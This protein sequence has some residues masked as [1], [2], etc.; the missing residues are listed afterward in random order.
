MD[1]RTLVK[2]LPLVTAVQIPASLAAQAPQTDQGMLVVRQGGREL[3]REEFALQPDPNPR[4]QGVTTLSVV[5]TVPGA[6]A[7]RMVIRFDPRTVTVRIATPT[8]EVAREY[9]GQR[10]LLFMDHD[11]FALHALTGGLEAGQVQIHFP[12]SG[13]RA[14]GTLEDAGA[15]RT[16]MGRQERDLR[17]RVLR[18]SDQTY[19]LWFDAAGRLM[20]ATAPD[21]GLVAERANP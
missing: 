10:G 16:M 13:S 17:H 8:G 14:T 21:R 12:R 19:H 6:P 3:A 2:V 11:I 18:V 1:V 4:A 7:T 9:P 5:R 20:K 15:E